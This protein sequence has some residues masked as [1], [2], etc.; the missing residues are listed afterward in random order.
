MSKIEINQEGK[1]E[2]QDF[3]F[4]VGGDSEAVERTKTE[5]FNDINEKTRQLVKE[6]DRVAKLK[7]TILPLLKK[8]QDSDDGSEKTAYIYW[9]NRKKMIEEQI[10]KV[11][12]I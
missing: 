2:V 3:G 8:L 7:D 4:T 9:P 11:E 12:G 5:M 6:Q 1:L 10:K